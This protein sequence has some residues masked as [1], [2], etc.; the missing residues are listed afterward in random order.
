MA[1]A[2]TSVSSRSK[3]AETASDSLI[4][5]GARKEDL[6]VIWER[7]V[8][9]GFESGH[10]YGKSLRTVKSCVGTTWCRYGQQDSVGFAIKL[11]N[12][13]KGIR[14]PHKLKGGVSGCI[15]ECAEAQV[16]FLYLSPFFYCHLT[17]DK[18][19][20]TSD[21]SPRTKG[22]TFMSAGMEGRNL[23]MQNYSSP[24]SRKRRPSST[25]IVSSF[26]IS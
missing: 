11:E 18:R 16:K 12:R 14:S 24:T 1:S 5:V 13:Y 23:N 21:V 22:T 26:T 3:V 2:L 9:A 8:D 10:A 25:S 20:K 15:R 17:N 6:P 19:V 7:L 4:T